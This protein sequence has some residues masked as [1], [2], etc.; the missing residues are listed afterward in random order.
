MKILP[1][2]RAKPATRPTRDVSI[3]GVPDEIA[4]RGDYLSRD[5]ALRV[6]QVKPQTLYSYVSRGFIRS[7]PQ[8]GLRGSFYLREDVEKVR[9]RSVSHAGHGP[10][11]ASAMRWGEPVITTSIT[12]LT[13][14][15]PRYRNRLAV[16]L[17][18]SGMPFENVAEYLWTGV[19]QDEPIVWS[20][21][22][23]PEKVGELISQAAALHER[24]HIMQL[25][26]MTVLGLGIAEGTRR[27][28]IRAGDTPVRAAR[29]L[30]RVLAGTLGY[31][32]TER[33]HSP[34]KEE[35]P[36]GA[37]LA[38]LFGLP[39]TASNINALTA[40]LIVVADHEL[41]PATFA[42]RVAASGSADL[43][44]CIGAALD[45]HYGTLVGRACD[46]L[47]QLLEPPAQPETVLQNAM[48]KLAA[49][50]S[51]PGFNHHHY[52]HGD[53]RARLLIDLALVVGGSRLVLGNMIASLRRLE[54]ECGVL[55]S[56]ECGLVFLCRALGLPDQSAGGIYALARTAGWAAHVFEQRLAG[57]VIRPRAQFTGI[58]READPLADGGS[59]D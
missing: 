23:E 52:P 47:E 32:G 50:R 49:A 16:D 46:R 1:G 33:R 9:S 41:N 30:I 12:E 3:P 42:A 10:A 26:A 51:L 43:H 36:L 37:A 5:Q 29:R 15:G 54:E 57:F 53:P 8:P 24:P 20:G 14:A 58:V 6:L 17:A 11:A 56:V 22:A 18:V 21:C 28:R 38:H 45:T 31:L 48:A 7:M 2:R 59:G 13:E 40:A 44:C 35:L 4:R 39:L 25:M 55:P 34:L 19:L 27:D